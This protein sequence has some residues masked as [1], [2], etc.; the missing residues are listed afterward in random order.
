MKRPSLKRQ[1][2]ILFLCVIIPVS[3][4][5]SLLLVYAA[6]YSRS[7]LAH[8]TAGNLQLFGS[9]LERQ[10]LA[11]ES[12][13]LNLS[14]NDAKLRNL[15]EE[16][17]RT[18][19]YLDLCELVQG[20]PALLAANDALMGIVLV[21]GA[22][23]MYKGAYGTV[24]GDSVQQLE[25]KRAMEAYLTR[26]GNFHSIHTAGWYMEQ[27]GGRLYLMR[28]VTTQK[29]ALTAAIDLR[30]LFEELLLGYGLD[31]QVLICDQQGQLLLG[32]AEPGLLDKVHWK[33]GYG[34]VR[35]ESGAELVVR[36]RVQ[37]LEVYYL[38]P[39]EHR[40]V[41]MGGYEMLLV[42]ASVFVITA[43][44]FL[45]IYMK[46]EIFRPMNVL[47]NTMDR[48][49]SGDLSARPDVDYRNAEFTQVNETFNH[50]IDQYEKEIEARRNEMTAL[51]LQI[52]PH[53]VLNCMKSVYALVQTGLRED[54][55]QLILL[56]SRYLRYILSFTSN[57][58][59]LS[60]EVEQCCN[61]ADLSS[62]GQPEPIRA[63]LLERE[64]EVMLC[65][66]EMPVESGLDLLKWMRD[67]EMRTRC[68]FLTAYA[69][70][71]YAQEAVRLGG[72]DYIMQPAP[73]G[74]V[75]ETVERALR[76]VRDERASQELQ[77]RGA[78]FD[79]Q[80]KEI[81][82]TLLRDV[83]TG[84][85]AGGNLKAFEEIGLFPQ[86]SQD[87]WL[88]LMQPLGCSR[89]R[90]PWSMPLL[91]AAVDNIC[92]EIFAPLEVLSIA[93]P[94]SREQGLAIVLQSQSGE[95]LEQD[96][97]LRQLAYLQ[98]A[99]EQYL[100]LG[101]AFYLTGPDPFAGAPAM[102]NKLLE[103]KNENVALKSGVYTGQERHGPRRENFHIHQ[104]AGWR[105]LMQE[106]YP[107][108]VEQE[109]C[110]LLDRLAAHNQLDRMELRLFYQ[111][112]MQMVFTSMETDQA[113]LRGM[114]RE[115]EA[116][117][118]YRNGMKTVD[119]M[120]A[121]IHYVAGSW[122]GGEAGR[123]QN[124]V[125]TVCRYVA[126]HLEEEL[127]REEL[128][129]VVHLNPD[130][131]NRMFK[132]ET[133]LTLKEYVIW[134]K[135]QEAQSLLRTTSLPVSLIAAKVGYSNFAH[136]STSYKNSFIAA[137][138]RNVRIHDRKTDRTQTISCREYGSAGGG[139]A[140]RLR[141]KTRR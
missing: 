46:Q 100:H 7:R 141:R 2:T 51:K 22:N 43:I 101:A 115:P 98:S 40:G 72:F 123:S 90:S 73:Y 71:Q 38:T 81:A 70:F 27:I 35:R 113:R 21:N 23:N 28:S 114:F 74:Q 54:A 56:L 45:F 4:L 107:Q 118:L 140:G 29:A 50:M 78:L 104:A 83:L 86:R 30:M 55:Q 96:A 129:E 137:R 37:L 89:Q 19:A 117:E 48:I 103:Q 91:G 106:G 116:L 97:V 132:K 16:T 77:T 82:A 49:S 39:Y 59:P 122:G 17:S 85:A 36:R 52:R 33:D 75:V 26:V 18:Q 53:F 62:I 61:Y 11:A 111:D 110:Q 109:A 119:A 5:L 10:M 76:E 31:G 121:L 105:R 65:D 92:S 108:T 66:I 133:G 135:M 42:L 57:T 6:E 34:V 93:V 69:K 126:E 102:W 47:V 32:E 138:R 12:Y 24:Y 60:S 58:A 139:S 124:A 64:A 41:A 120:K 20:F 1:L 127:R 125:E 99:C 63:S 3:L 14:L 131:L 13:L 95:A 134:Q 8:T 9:T 44:P 87:C 130:Y 15:S 136:F 94:M 25:Q 67:R 68:I 79:R 80:K 88:V 112:F 128:A 84:A